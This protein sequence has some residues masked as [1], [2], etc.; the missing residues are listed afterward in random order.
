MK[1]L[2]TRGTQCEDKKANGMREDILWNW[3]ALWTFSSAPGAELTCNS[4][5]RAL[6]KGVLWRKG[7]SGTQSES[8]NRFTERILTVA[9]TCRRQ[10]LNLMNFPVDAVK[11]HATE[12]SVPYLMPV[13]SG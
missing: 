8:G 6:R 1:R 3:K 12:K 9:E 10:G 7:N 2:L 5:E 11:A 4:A 13:P